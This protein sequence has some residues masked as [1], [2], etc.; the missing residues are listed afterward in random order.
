MKVVLPW[1]VADQAREPL[2]EGGEVVQ[3]LRGEPPAKDGVHAIDELPRLLP[4]ADVVIVVVPLTDET[5]G[6]VDAEFLARLHDGALLVNAARGPVVDTDA[7]VAALASGR[8]TAALDVTDPE[9]L[10]AGHP[11]WKAP[12]LL[13]TPH[14]GGDTTNYKARLHRLVR[15]QVARRL[16][17]EPLHNVVEDG[18]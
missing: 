4:Y 18:Y 8:I 16:A 1:P 9:P 15:E 11:L 12:G 17:G 5:R 6:M 10:P 13:L 7:L 3:S 14:I 2:P